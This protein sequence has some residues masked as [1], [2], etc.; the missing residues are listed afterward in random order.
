MEKLT[1]TNGLGSNGHNSLNRKKFS[2]DGSTGSPARHPLTTQLAYIK[3]SVFPGVHKHQYAWPFHEPV[4]VVKLSLPV[5]YF[6]LFL[7]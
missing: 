2:A 5:S 1:L 4:D 3:R 6:L 7:V